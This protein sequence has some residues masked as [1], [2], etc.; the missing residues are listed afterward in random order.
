MVT[1][2]AAVIGGEAQRVRPGDVQPLSCLKRRGSVERAG[3]GTLPS[4]RA[5][6]VARPSARGHGRG[7]P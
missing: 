2:A 5:G 3:D 6:R 4:P 7:V 1:H